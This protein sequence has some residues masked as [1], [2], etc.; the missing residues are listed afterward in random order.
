MTPICHVE[1]GDDGDPLRNERLLRSLYAHLNEQDGIRAEVVAARAT[2]S[3]G[4]KGGETEGYA[5]LAVFSLAAI[6]VITPVMVE[7][8]RAW[9]AARANRTVRLIRGRNALEIKGTQ[10]SADMEIIRTFLDQ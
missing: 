9:S 2:P 4:S 10:R 5:A 6:K 7:A 1:V 8:I 3:A